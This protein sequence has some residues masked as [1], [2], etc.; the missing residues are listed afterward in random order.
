M[1]QDKKIVILGG[2]SPYIPQ[3]I[4]KIVEYKIHETIS[5][6]WLV[7]DEDQ[8]DYLLSVHDFSNKI[9]KYYQSDIK[10][11]ASTEMLESLKDADYVLSCIG[12]YVDSSDLSDEKLLC[13][14][15]LFSSDLYGMKSIFKAIKTIPKIYQAIEMMNTACENAWF[16]N[17][18]QPMGII[19]ESVFRYA[20]IEKYIGISNVPEDM[21]ECFAKALHVKT[22]QL[23]TYAAGVNPLTYITSVFQKQ[24]DRLH[25]LLDIINRAEEFCFWSNTFL[26]DLGVFPSVDLKML[27]YHD[28]EKQ[29]FL[30]KCRQ[31]KSPMTM[32]KAFETNLYKMFQK[33][34]IEEV[35]KTYQSSDFEIYSSKAAKL[36]NALIKDKRDYQ[37]I[38][39]INNGHVEDLEEGCAVEVTARITKDGPI[40]VHVSRLPLQIKGLLQHQKAF[41]QLLSDAIYLKDLDKVSLAIKSHPLMFNIREVDI[42]FQSYRLLNE[43]RLT[44]YHKE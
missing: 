41:E 18:S 37:I 25:E 24:K 8:H 3:L 12:L 44:Y 13:E 19:S 39:T 22:N 34:S 33:S 14:N 31:N 4:A 11:F 27:Y 17:L 21:N 16:I 7:D 26:N 9:L 1:N 5:E 36:L 43:K 20:E 15:D 30:K 10:L 38:N 32:K 29:T 23:I 42:I 2:A 40:P 35:L 6:I 28:D